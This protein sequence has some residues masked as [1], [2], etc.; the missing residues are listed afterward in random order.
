MYTLETRYQPIPPKVL[1]KSKEPRVYY[2]EPKR[3]EQPLVH[4]GGMTTGKSFVLFHTEKRLL[5]ATSILVEE[6]P[7]QMIILEPKVI[8]QPVLYSIVGAKSLPLEGKQFASTIF[9]K[10]DFP[11]L[12]VVANQTSRPANIIPPTV[13]V[14]PPV[15]E[16]SPVLYSL[17]AN[18]RLNVQIQEPAKETAAIPQQSSSTLYTVVGNPRMTAPIPTT[19]VPA[20][21]VTVKQTSPILYS[22]VANPR[23][24]SN[25]T[26]TNT[27]NAPPPAPPVKPSSVQPAP[28]LY[29]LVG[30]T[31]VPTETVKANRTPLA[32]IKRQTNGNATR[33]VVG[34]P[35]VPRKIQSIPPTKQSQ[36][37]PPIS[38]PLLYSIVGQPNLSSERK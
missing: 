1:P 11:L 6:E 9:S 10:I 29:T 19:H 22:I 32:P 36:P 26:Y 16:A 31:Q 3:D 2:I 33:A 23:L 15:P 30:E 21:P 4:N 8:S 25:L 18:P 27:P 20:A 5:S 35:T 38:T 24:T 17:V 14:P 28:I 37:L 13:N 12:C 7:A 34:D